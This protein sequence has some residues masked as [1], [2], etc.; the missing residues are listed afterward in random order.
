MLTVRTDTKGEKIMRSSTQRHFARIPRVNVRRS[1]FNRD[2]TYK[3]TFNAGG[4]VPVFV[5]EVI[6]GDTF[7]LDFN[8]F[9]RLTTPIVPFM[10]NLYLE[11]FFFYV[12]TRL[13]W[14]NFQAF[15][16]EQKNPDSSTDFLVPTLT[17]TN[18]PTHTVWDFFGLPTYIDNP[19]T[20]NALPFRAYYLIYN[21]WFRDEN[22]V[23]SEGFNTIEGTITNDGPD[24][25]AVN[26]GAVV[27]RGKRHDYFTSALPWPQ[28]G[29]GVDIPLTGDALI[30]VP[31]SNTDNGQQDG[32]GNVGIK[33]TTASSPGNALDVWINGNP[34]TQQIYTPYGPQYAYADL[35]SVSG[36]TINSLR[37][38]FQLQKFYELNARGGTRYTEILRA[39]FGV[40]SPDARLQR[41]EYLGGGSRRIVVKPVEQNSATDSTSPQGNLAAYALA[42]D[43]KHVF[44]KSFVEHGYV[45]GLI[46]VR[47]DLTYQQGINRMWSRQTKEDFYWP[48]FAHLGEQAI[49]NKEIF[50]QGTSVDDQVF[51][52]QERYAE[53]RYKPSMITGR[54]R[55]SCPQPLDVWHLSQYFEDLPTLSENFIND[56]PPVARVVAVQTEPQFLF[57]SLINL[58]CVRPMPVYSV[59]GLVDHF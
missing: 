34:A 17:C 31:Y 9:C 55:S 57:D 56:N 32:I 39:H 52:Y 26:G 58:K 42:G 25:L 40:V 35:S 54:F 49:L 27:N 13:V 18:V 10:D 11:Y 4:L 22:L 50:A 47:A 7:S 24:T 45:I 21:E 37:Q 53:Y 46:N 3:T 38:A 48:V 36:V 5:D 16:G 41:P 20:V 23:P 33:Y 19:L 28:K 43:S 15:M 6:P 12:P 51:G 14:D 2:H 29:P 59:P 44:T 30:K 8:F 1:V